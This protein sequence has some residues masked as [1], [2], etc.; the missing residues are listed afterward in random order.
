MEDNKTAAQLFSEKQ[1]DFGKSTE[2]ARKWALA[3]GAE[4]VKGCNS[5]YLGNYLK[6]KDG[7][8][9]SIDCGFGLPNIKI[10]VERPD[11]FTYLGHDEPVHDP[12]SL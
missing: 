4:E 1:N 12:G 6:F 10:N 11:S 8:V 3:Q 7:S 2:D 5:F 9:A